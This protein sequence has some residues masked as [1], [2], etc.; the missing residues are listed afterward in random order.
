MEC[1]IAA[2]NKLVAHDTSANSSS[3]AEFFDYLC[4]REREYSAEFSSTRREDLQKA[5]QSLTQAK[6]IL[7]MLVEEVPSSNQLVQACKL[8]LSS[9]LFMS[10][11]EVLAYFNYHVTFPFLNDKKSGVA[12]PG[13]LQ[14]FV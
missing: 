11:L 12:S 6:D 4:E 10:E 14:G 2:L 8:Y 13:C 7:K 9:E 3:Q 1:G 5:S